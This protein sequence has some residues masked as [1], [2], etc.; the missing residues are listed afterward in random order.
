MAIYDVIPDCIL[1]LDMPVEV[2]LPRTFDDQN[3]KLEK[4]G[5]AFYQEVVRG[6]EIIAHLP[7]FQKKWI[8]I[9]ANADQET[10]EERVQK[11]VLDF[12]HI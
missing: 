6:Y 4:M 10:V 7:E 11:A 2:A 3:D 1:S 12:F 9:D 8:H 5:K